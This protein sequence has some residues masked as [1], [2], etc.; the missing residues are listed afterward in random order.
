[1]ENN[2]GFENKKKACDISECHLCDNGYCNSKV[3]LI[4]QKPNSRLCGGYKLVIKENVAFTFNSVMEIRHLVR[5]N[6]NVQFVVVD[7]ESTRVRCYYEIF[8]GKEKVAIIQ[9]E[10]KNEEIFIFK[11]SV[12]G[13]V[14]L[15]DKAQTELNFLNIS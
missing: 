14:V 12:D 3:L 9:I 10:E 4:Y 8:E 5:I 7:P 15:I 13:G 6:P 2:I 1:M 11:P